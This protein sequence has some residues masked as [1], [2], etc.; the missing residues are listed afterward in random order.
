MSPTPGCSG[1]RPGQIG[2]WPVRPAETSGRTPWRC[3]TGR[4]VPSRWADRWFFLGKRVSPRAVQVVSVGSVFRPW[5]PRA[6]GGATAVRLIGSPGAGRGRGSLVEGV[7]DRALGRT[8]S[9][10]RLPPGGGRNGI[11]PVAADH[12][13]GPSARLSARGRRGRGG[14]GAARERHGSGGGVGRVIDR[15]ETGRRPPARPPVRDTT[16]G[17]PPGRAAEARRARA[18][19]G[20]PVWCSARRA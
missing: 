13:S 19:G 20:S 18:G 8:G 17:R 1:R 3:I 5:E 14:K 9:G 10:L 4:C 2:D 7:S 11:L 12:R 15:P 16:R 6:G